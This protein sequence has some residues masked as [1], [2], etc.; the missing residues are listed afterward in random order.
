MDKIVIIGGNNLSGEVVVSGSKNAALPIMAAVLLASGEYELDNVPELNDITSMS[1]LLEVIGAEVK[2]S[3]HRLN[4]KTT[5]CDTFEAPYDLVKKMRA[6]IYVL[7]PLVGRFGYAKVSLPGGCAWGPR[8]INLHLEGLKRLGVDISL[9]EGY[10][11][12]RSKKLKGNVIEFDITT[13]GGTANIMM[14][15]VLAKG[16]TVIENAAK[17]PEIVTLANFLIKMS[18]KINGAGTDRIE[19]E[20]VNELYSVNDTIIPDRIEAATFIASAAITKGK[21]TIKKSN[22]E[23]LNFIILKFEEAGIKFNIKDSDIVVDTPDKLK[24]VNITTNPYPGFPTDMQAQWTALM[25]VTPGMSV[26]KD[27]IYYDRFSHVPELKRLGADIKVENNSA[28]IKGVSELKGASVMSTDLRASASLIIAGLA[29]KGRTDVLRVYHID[30]GYER[31][32]EKLK[33]LGAQIWREKT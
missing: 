1:K 30:R 8:P 26:V 7:G 11:I 29:A 21:I 31:I 20:G 18:A 15:A 6:S 17:E 13:V 14:A 33:K 25:S 12:A 3:Q 16:N 19:I 9:E 5:E 2:F 23:H 4:I 10:I 27:T 28:I 32:E 22:P 24:P